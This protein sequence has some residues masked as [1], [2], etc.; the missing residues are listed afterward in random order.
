M[1]RSNR[2]S[3]ILFVLGMSLLTAGAAIPL[4]AQITTLH[5]FVGTD[6]SV[7]QGALVQVS[8]GEFYGTT[9]GGG[10]TGDGSAYRMTPTGTLTTVH[11]FDGTDGSGPTDALIQ[12]TDGNLYGTTYGGGASGNGTV[13]KMSL[14]GTVTTLHSFD[15]SDGANV[16]AG[17]VQGTDGNF[18]GTATG[19]GS[20]GYGTAYKI[21][22]A[23]VFTLLHNFVAG[24]HDGAYP[25]ATLIQATDG[26]FYGTTFS[27][28][29][30]FEG[31]VFRMTPSGTV[32]VIHAFCI[33]GI[34]C[35]DGGNVQAGLV[36]ASNG[37]LY[38]TV[39]R[40]GST[41]CTL[42]FYDGC[43]TVFEIGL[44][45]GFT[46]LHLFELTDGAGPVSKLIQ[47]KSGKLYG[48]TPYGGA[49]NECTSG[50]GTIFNI[51]LSGI[52]TSVY[53]FCSESGCTDGS[54]PVANLIQAAKGP[55]YGTTGS[56]GA[57]GDGTV[58]DLP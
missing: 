8:N 28:G 35:P 55:L 41:T 13:F 25:Y 38:G 26:N 7:P 39:V 46:T 21:T 11:S 17:L 58:Y 9:T 53:S 24:A 12:A 34:P 48:V 6:G 56:G 45:G 31:T 23:G 5:S 19:G 57:D 16:F 33:A 51:T 36:Q 32:T 49:N 40:G 1:T 18:Y 27:G 43:G 4:A 47:A 37:K 50:C 52:F 14:S 30:A 29:G 44:G 22:P 3:S 10:A 20:S 15:G 42:D 54:L 2:R